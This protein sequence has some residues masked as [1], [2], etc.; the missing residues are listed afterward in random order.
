MSKDTKIQWCD[1][2]LN[3]QMG[4]DGCELWTKTVRKCYAGRQCEERRMFKGWPRQFSEPEIYMDRLEPALKW[5]DLTGTDREDKP[6][7]NGM[8]RI[9]F[10]NDMG[11]TFSST[12]PPNWLAPVLPRLATSPHQFLLLTK[13]PSRL[14]EFCEKYTLPKNVWPGTSVTSARTAG[15]VDY[16]RQI[17]TGGPKFVSCEPIWEY[18]PP[19]TFSELQWAIFG[20]ESG[21]PEDA[22]PCNVDWIERGM[23]NAM[24]A[25]ASPFVKQL[26]SRPYWQDPVLDTPTPITLENHHGG[27]WSEW[28]QRLRKRFMPAC[29]YAPILL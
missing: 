7:L 26:G 24:Q 22:T 29:T 5:K 16:I 3:L 18:L 27:D 6:W 2:S 19:E 1:S 20:G 4:C 8:P 28:P 11:D 21:D 12:L 14:L 10:L 13:R 23:L 25:G 9:V 15:R 17:K